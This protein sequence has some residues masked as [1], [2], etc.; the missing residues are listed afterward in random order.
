MQKKPEVRESAGGAEELYESVSRILRDAERHV[1][2]LEDFAEL[3][4]T[5]AE[6][7]PEASRKIIGSVNFGYRK[8][9]GTA[10]N[11]VLAYVMKRVHSGELSVSGRERKSSWEKGWGKNL[12]AFLASGGDEKALIPKYI[13]SRQP[14]RLHQQYILPEDESF[15]WDWYRVFRPW[16]FENH[17]Q[18][19]DTVYE[20]GCGTGFNLVELAR[21]FPDK[22]FVG[23]D[24]CE[25]SREIVRLLAERCGLPVEGR[26]FDF[27]NPDRD[28]KLEKNSAVLTIGA[29]EQ[30]GRNYGKFTDWLLGSGVKRCV[31]V[32]PVLEW[33]DENH[34]VD[35]A[36]REFHRARGYWQG[37]PELL[38]KLEAEGR[39]EILKEKR[40]FFG[41][42]Y[43][44]GY[45]QLMWRP[46]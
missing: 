15:E 40:S 10:E 37:F 25:S 20:F 35:Q 21:L 11:E 16:L 34:P 17:F 41:S 19:V 14:V 30:T 46:K 18:D 22:R 2:G 32:E 24:W 44:E 8:I 7:I 13:H 4:G 5:P 33:Y 42:L 39:V 6:K 31:H 28:M 43:V 45:S 26:L 23:L 29:L 36:A 9:T 27:F 12:E 38:R 1:L 3:F